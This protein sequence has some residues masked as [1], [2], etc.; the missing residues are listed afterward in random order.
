MSASV[1]SSEVHSLP[2]L[3]L[4]FTLFVAQA[5]PHST[6]PKFDPLFLSLL[7]FHFAVT[8]ISLILNQDQ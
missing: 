3:F 6:F 1:F 5:V 4:C 2:G 8:C 7:S